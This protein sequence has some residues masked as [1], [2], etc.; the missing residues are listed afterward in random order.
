[1]DS[2]GFCT[3]QCLG[4]S[5]IGVWRRNDDSIVVRG[6]TKPVSGVDMSPD[7]QTAILFHPEK[8]E[9]LTVHLT[10]TIATGFR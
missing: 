4:Q 5:R 10:S 3:Q 1:M 9:M 7:S 2:R 8:M 6:T